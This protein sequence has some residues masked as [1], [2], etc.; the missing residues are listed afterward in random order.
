MSFNFNDRCMVKEAIEDGGGGRDI[1]DE[2]TPFFEG[3]VGCHECGFDF[4]SAHDDFKEVFAGAGRELLYAHV[5]D[6]EQV[7][8]EVTLHH[9][10]MGVFRTGLV[11]VIKDIKDGT[12]EDEFALFDELVADCLC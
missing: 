3:T 1:T 11:K 2:L 5:I 8:L 10:I 12:I 4:I 6:N 7:A 9:A